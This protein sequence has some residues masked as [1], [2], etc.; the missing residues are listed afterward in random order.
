VRLDRITTVAELIEAIEILQVRAGAK[1]VASTSFK[2]APLRDEVGNCSPNLLQ[3]PEINPGEELVQSGESYT[4]A[5]VLR[6]TILE[7]G[8]VANVPLLSQSGVRRLDALLLANGDHWKY[9]KRPNCGVV[10]A[11][12]VI[13]IDWM[14]SK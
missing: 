13:S 6:V 10:Q 8:E 14:P 2:T 4:G 7:S 3:H 9:A 12:T 11:N 5:P 1:R